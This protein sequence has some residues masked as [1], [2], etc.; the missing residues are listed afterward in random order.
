MSETDLRQKLG[1]PPNADVV[2]IDLDADRES[3]GA[4]L[5]SGW[6]DEQIRAKSLTELEQMAENQAHLVR[7]LTDTIDTERVRLQSFEALVSRRR[8]LS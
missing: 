8:E 5:T 7:T 1:I 3:K 6:T 4:R 2:V